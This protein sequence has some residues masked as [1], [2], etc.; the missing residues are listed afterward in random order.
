MREPSWGWPGIT[1]QVHSLARLS[2]PCWAGDGQESPLKYTERNRLVIF[3]VA[4]DGQESPLK[5]TRII[6]SSGSIMAGDGQESP[7]KYTPP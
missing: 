2:F 7:L 4:G 5:Y 1:A 3:V 6:S